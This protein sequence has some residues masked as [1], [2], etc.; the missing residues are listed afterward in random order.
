MLWPCLIA[1]VFTSFATP[2]A[3]QSL[4]YK[5]MRIQKIDG[6]R[7]GEV[8]SLAQD[9][10]GFIW[11]GTIDGLFRYDGYSLKGYKHDRN[12]ST[13]IGNNLIFSLLV[14]R[15]GTLWV[16]TSGGGLNRF[17]RKTESFVQYQYRRGDPS[18][19][20]AVVVSA[21]YE[22]RHGTL[23]VGT[24][25]GLNR[26]NRETGKFT[27]FLYDPEDE[28]LMGPDENH[29]FDIYE[30]PA[31]GAGLWLATGGAG[32]VRLD[33]RSGKVT[34]FRHDPNDAESL[35]SSRISSI[36]PAADGTLWIGTTNGL[37]RFDPVSGRSRRWGHGPADSQRLIS[38]FV[39]S[40]HRD[41]AHPE[42]IWVGTIDGLNLLD[43]H[44]GKVIQF[45]SKENN[46]RSLSD[47]FINVIFEDAAGALWFGTSDGV[48]RFDR[49]RQFFSHLEHDP[50]DPNSLSYPAV[51]AITVD[52]AF[53]DTIWIGT[54]RGLNRYSRR[55]GEFTRFYHNAGDSQSLS[56]D[57]VITLY[58]DSSA[59][60]ALWIGTIYGLNRMDRR[61]GLVQRYM[62]N[63]R[64]PN[65]LRGNTIRSIKRDPFVPNRLWVGTFAGGLNALDPS[66]GGFEHFQH[67]PADP[68]SLSHTGVWDLQVGDDGSVWVAT[69]G[70][71]VSRLMPGRGGFL[72]Y[73]KDDS[74][75]RS[76]SHDWVG[77]VYEDRR[78]T[79]WAT[80]WYGGLNRLQPDGRS[81]RVYTEND[82]L[83]SSHIVSIVED[84]SGRL[85]MA[86][87]QG[88]ARFDPRNETFKNFTQDDGLLNRTYQWN[89][90][91]RSA[92][93]ELFFGGDRG[94]DWFHPDSIRDN[95]YI[96]PVVFTRLLRF[97][98]GEQ[99][100]GVVE[101]PGSSEI[102]D[103]VL[104]YSNRI[105]QVEFAA[106][107][108]QMPARNR[109][110]YW[111]E[112]LNRNWIQL[113]RKH[114]VSFTDLS[115][116]RYTL[117]VKGS[118]NDGLWNEVGA[119]LQITVLAPW[120]RT[121][122]AYAAYSVLLLMLLYGIRH[123]ELKRFRLKKALEIKNVEAE[124]LQE[125]ARMQ[126]RFFAGISHEFRTPLTL[127]LGPV[128][129]W[130]SSSAPSPQKE[131]YAMVQRSARRLQRLINQLLDL[132]KLEAGAMRLQA[133]RHNLVELVRTSTAMF[134]SL[135]RQKTLILEFHSAEVEL[136]V[137]IERH[138]VETI[139]SNLIANAVKFTP[140]P[141]RITVTVSRVEESNENA[142]QAEIR[143][144]DDGIG[145]DADQ[146]DKIFDRFYQVSRE[147][148]WSGTGIGLALVKE[149]VELHHG[150]ITVERNESGGAT[151]VVTLPAGVEHLS[152]EEMVKS[153]EPESAATCDGTEKGEI[154]AAAAECTPAAGKRAL[155]LLV[156][157]N[158]DMRAYLRDRL[159]HRFV[160]VEAADGR[161]GWEAAL[162]HDPDCIVSDV[163][164]PEMDGF[165]FCKKLKSDGRTSHVPL[166]LLTARASRGSRLDGL[167]LG[168]D[169]Y[170]TKPFDAGE[171]E[172]RICNLIRQR[173]MLHERFRRSLTIEPENLAA[174]SMDEAFLQRVMAVVEENLGDAEFS[175]DD[176]ARASGFSRRQLN[177]KLRALTGQ[178][179]REFI[180][181]VRLKRAA[182]L[183]RQNAGTVTEIAYEVGF[184]S[185]PYFAKIFRRQ[186]GVN[187][188]RFGRDRAEETP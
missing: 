138:H 83:P 18:S 53:P 121:P 32:L 127:I 112:G 92:G 171:L 105:F 163:M 46:L 6:H 26:L 16:G 142:G 39:L 31:P 140:D 156:D 24:W 126:S 70:G 100:G 97:G 82:G 118:N 167:G 80:T 5:F 52:P 25:S 186:F 47:N 136:P 33:R 141:G 23:W 164:M 148:R 21:I 87:L 122:W 132:S 85:W 151:F 77:V 10:Q 149:L 1:L 89:A 99:N 107:N 67:S 42:L 114:E 63:D 75:P 72:H 133:R 51:A 65:G 22:D 182:Q 28:P 84:D 153:A 17:D 14:D 125:V 96:P 49:L 27:R 152:P 3:A 95:P 150:R 168:A 158:P 86:T 55:Q 19:L 48:S 137:W 78:G 54:A 37:N 81:F 68:R 4:N 44:T 155:V 139:V 45:P 57:R 88:L 58:A 73:R 135:A 165:A 145:I 9:Q 110:A 124:K 20:N 117:R 170:L 119:T 71:G 12:D 166:I 38:D 183:L 79:L 7:L 130:L 134:E 175:T 2:I 143:V 120:W 93:G 180:R 64:D 176:L 169:D 115:P 184:N 11:L 179:T 131:E 43:T 13:S 146:F 8:H 35:S 36:L 173:K 123:V 98:G 157:D 94:V 50:E 159:Q 147:G 174:T 30:E 66:T 144:C 187:P 116:G 161:Q 177:R 104:P 154:A 69:P 40:L 74:N 29:V 113:G 61:T 60:G 102:R 101:V 188:S 103:I 108:Y 162:E 59:D 56:H 90:V 106:L 181:T 111:L 128:E 41:T 160:L 178:S 15:S 62:H 91:T 129:K 172:A 34:R 185:I 76:L 109:Y